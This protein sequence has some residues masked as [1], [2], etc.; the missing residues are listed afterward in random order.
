MQLY[1]SCNTVANAPAF[2]PHS[3]PDWVVSRN[4]SPLPIEDDHGVTKAA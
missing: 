4:I 1:I 3:R 2:G